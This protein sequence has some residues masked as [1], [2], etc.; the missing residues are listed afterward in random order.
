[1]TSCASAGR[2]WGQD[3]LRRDRWHS[4]ASRVY[5]G[6][7]LGD[8]RGR[9]HFRAVRLLC[10]SIYG[11]TAV[12]GLH[13]SALVDKLGKTSEVS[14]RRVDNFVAVR[15]L[16]GKRGSSW[17]YLNEPSGTALTGRI[18]SVFPRTSRS[19]WATALVDVEVEPA[20]PL[21]FLARSL[22]NVFSH[23]PP[24]LQPDTSNEQ[25]PLT[26]LIWSNH[27]SIACRVVYGCGAP[28]MYVSLNRHQLCLR[29]CIA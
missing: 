19:A 5:C 18:Q 3:S 24:G 17:A 12:S 11:R 21:H 7:R 9:H 10:P 1:M 16:G 6:K 28:C 29:R 26:H 8:L 27:M 2:F 23:T 22:V 14:E 25:R 4:D 20:G 13:S 15:V